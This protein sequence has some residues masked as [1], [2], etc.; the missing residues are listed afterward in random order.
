MSRVL[1][2]GDIHAPCERNGYLEFCQD[3]YDAWSC[4]TVVF[5]GDVVD[6]HAISF[7]AMNPEA[8]GPKDE[9]K[10]TLKAIKKWYSVF[11]NAKV[12]LGNHDKRVVR[13]AASS[14]ITKF[15]LKSYSKTWETPN[16]EWGVKFTI[17]GVRYFH[18]EKCSGMHPAYNAARKRGQSVCIGHCHSRGGIKWL[19][20]DEKRW[21][22]MDVGTGVDD[23]AWAFAYAEEQIEKSIVSCGII[24]DGMPYHEMMPLEEYK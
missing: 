22:G 8:P 11:P 2:I 21:F 24:I 1:A 5:M 23:D 16:W 9:A 4:D 12:C 20:N 19:C 10:L 17:D 13:L 3:M 14:K 7:H 6:H 15:F 18:G